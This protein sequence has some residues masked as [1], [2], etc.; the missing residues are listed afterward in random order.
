MRQENLAKQF[1]V[2]LK[3]EN[4]EVPLGKK[5]IDQV[6]PDARAHRNNTIC[7]LDESGENPFYPG[8][9]FMTIRLP[10][11]VVRTLTH[12]ARS[13]IGAAQGSSAV[14]A[15]FRPLRH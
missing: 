13:G 2:Y 3:D 9:Y 10:Q 5:K 11:T 6:I 4:C 14:D 12:A 7:M 1:V 15:D 8:D